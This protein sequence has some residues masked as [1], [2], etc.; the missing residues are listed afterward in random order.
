MSTEPKPFV[1]TLT[2]EEAAEIPVAVG[3]GGHQDTHRR[4]TQDL[5]HGLQVT[6]DDRELGELIRYMTRYRSGGFQSRL[7]RAFRRSLRELLDF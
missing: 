7:K 3:S 5:Q 6:F 2:P 1:F 4:L